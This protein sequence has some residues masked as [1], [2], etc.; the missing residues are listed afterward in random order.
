MKFTFFVHSLV[1]CW[2]HGNA[3]FLRGIVRALQ[4]AGHHVRVYEP[5]GS[6][7]LTQLLADQGEAGL[8]PMRRIYPDLKAR[9][10][11]AGSNFEHLVGDCDVVIAHEWTEPW[12]LDALARA[13]RNRHFLFLFHDTHHRAVSDPAR[14]HGAWMNDCDGILVFGASLADVYTKKNWHDRIFVWHEAADTSVFKPPAIETIRHGLVFIGNWGDNERNAALGQFLLRPAQASGSPLDIFGVRYPASACGILAAHSA[15]YRGF[16]ANADVPSRFAHYRA[17]IHI[18]RSF[19]VRHLPG[20]PTIRVFEALACGIP[21]LSAP[22]ADDEELFTPDSFIM[23]RTN[24]EME[25]A[26]QSIL[27]DDDLWHYLSK[28]GLQQ[29]QSRHS[30]AVRAQ[31]LINIID[32]L[33]PQETRVA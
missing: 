21:L 25:R 10:Y 12:A 33:R 3:H 30:C 22:W 18:P 7:S 11:H 4:K 26:M 8:A 31:E 14:L 6:W 28:N 24:R 29:I 20:I 27:H 16:V 23:A 15:H 1:S 19:Y 5:Q 9:T 2:N 13:R 17:T 32:T